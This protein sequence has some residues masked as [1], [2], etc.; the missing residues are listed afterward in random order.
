MSPLVVLGLLGTV[1]STVTLIPHVAHAIRSGRPGGSPSGWVLSFGGSMVWGVY[2]IAG[3]DLLVAAP[4]L[5]T[6]PCGLLLAGWSI[7]DHVRRSAATL[8]APRVAESVADSVAELVAEPVGEPVA[9]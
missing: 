7:L 6:V 2:G 8:L 5:V 4:G 9:A 3:H 1:F